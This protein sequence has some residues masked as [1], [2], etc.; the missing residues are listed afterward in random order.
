MKV[1]RVTHWLKPGERKNR[2]SA[3]VTRNREQTCDI[4]E[5]LCG[6]CVYTSMKV[7]PVPLEQLLV[8]N[9]AFIPF[10]S[11]EATDVCSKQKAFWEPVTDFGQTPWTSR[12]IPKP[13]QT[14]LEIDRW[15]LLRAAL[16]QLCACT[17]LRLCTCVYSVCVCVLSHMQK[18]WEKQTQIAASFL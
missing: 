10:S 9:L 3:G 17:Y 11:R 7:S 6:L 12:L 2:D 1:L 13:R 5:G 14:L 16:F 18:R 4:E 8:L 15:L